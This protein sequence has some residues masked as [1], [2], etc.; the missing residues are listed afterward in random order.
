M[1]SKRCGILAVPC[2][3][4]LLLGNFAFCP[5][6]PWPVFQVPAKQGSLHLANKSVKIDEIR[7]KKRL[8]ASLAEACCFG[9]W[10][11]SSSVRAFAASD[12]TT[13]ASS[14]ET[15]EAVP[16]TSARCFFRYRDRLKDRVAMQQQAVCVPVLPQLVLSLKASGMLRALQ[17]GVVGVLLVTFSILLRVIHAMIPG[18][19]IVLV[20]YAIYRLTKANAWNRRTVF[21][22][23]LAMLLTYG[24]IRIGTKMGQPAALLSRSAKH[25]VPKHS[26]V[27]AGYVEG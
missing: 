13:A 14:F 20:C 26:Q 3:T 4:Q 25:V 17:N 9:V 10:V 11:W 8:R 7:R 2:Q 6:E 5:T 24:L 23:T 16:T 19:A 21:L 12:L 22:L 27:H 18:M 15:Q 1:A